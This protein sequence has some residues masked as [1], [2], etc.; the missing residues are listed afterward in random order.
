[1]SDLEILT[2]ADRDRWLAVLSSVERYDF[3]DLPQYHELAERTGGG[4]GRLLVYEYPGGVI[5]LPLMFRP[6][7]AIEGLQGESSLDAG[8]VYGYAGPLSTRPLP[9]ADVIADF[10]SSI[11]R[12]LGSLEVVALFS[13]LHPLI[14]QAELISGLGEVTASGITVS[15][16]LTLSLEEQLAQYRLNHVRGI[17]KLRATGAVCDIDETQGLS[18]F[19]EMYRETMSRVGAAPQYFFNDEYF[20]LLQNLLGS[21]VKLFTCTLGD[22]VIAAGLFL[23]CGGIVQ[24]HLG[25]T[26]SE[27]V[28]LS[29]MKLIIDRVRQWATEAGMTVLHLGGGIGA[30][31]DSLFHF[32]AGFSNRRH[33]YT[34]WR[35]VP[36]PKQY[37]RITA[38]KA[39]WNAERG[40]RF[41]STGHFPLYRSRVVPIATPPVSRR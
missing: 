4:Q 14:P 25:A 21:R 16:D 19:V 34:T 24:Y 35:W 27:Y 28:Q 13:T 17:R 12:V 22:A 39:A 26:R 7:S 38:R 29:P 30:Q 33:Q 41:T 11:G 37:D 36:D 8:S 10:K 23:V 32:K 9:P 6:C 2:T 20:A 5:A 1:M 15:I 31:E 40:L 3:Y 18:Q